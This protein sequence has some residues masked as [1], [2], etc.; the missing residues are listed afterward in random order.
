ML[1][2]E[3]AEL[4][5]KLEDTVLVILYLPRITLALVGTHSK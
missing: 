5:R 2:D 3:T 4:R 1:V